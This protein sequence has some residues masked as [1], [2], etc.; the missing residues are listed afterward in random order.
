MEV[1]AGEGSLDEMKL[2]GGEGEL[3]AL[4]LYLVVG[5]KEANAVL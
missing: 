5:E 2:P 3:T 1:G 4:P